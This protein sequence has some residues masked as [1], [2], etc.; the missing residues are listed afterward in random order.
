MREAAAAPEYQAIARL[1]APLI[2]PGARLQ[3][4]PSP[5]AAALLRELA[6]PVR[7][8]SGLLPEGVV[9]LDERGLL[10]AEPVAAYLAG[11]PRAY[12]SSEGRTL[13]HPH[14]HSHELRKVAVD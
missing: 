4:G 9:D 11:G 14:Q 1:I 8:G 10:G 12:G 6:A 7:L 2:A 3:V 13:P 5:V